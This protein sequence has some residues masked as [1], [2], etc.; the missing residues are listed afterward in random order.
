MKI[1]LGHAG[2]TRVVLMGAVAGIIVACSYAPVPVQSKSD[3]QS[4]PKAFPVRFTHVGYNTGL[5]PDNRYEHIHL[6]DSSG[7]M[8]DLSGWRISSPATGDSFVFP[9]GAKAKECTPAT[10]TTVNTH[11]VGNEDNVRTFSWRKPPGQNEWP[12]NGGVAHLYNASNELVDVCT[13]TSSRW[14]DGNAKCK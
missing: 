3:G 11:V 9:A 13:Y 14:D 4:N 6:C 1:Y 10:E 2:L 12:D 8:T 7:S 5:Y